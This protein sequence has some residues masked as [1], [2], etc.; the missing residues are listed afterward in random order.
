VPEHTKYCFVE[1]N[2]PKATSDGNANETTTAHFPRV[3]FTEEV[4]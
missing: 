1:R 4:P 2:L 3:I